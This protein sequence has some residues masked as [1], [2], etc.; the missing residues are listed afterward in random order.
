LYSR[1]DAAEKH[2]MMH[3]KLICHGFQQS[4]AQTAFLNCLEDISAKK[5]SLRLKAPVTG[6]QELQEKL[7]LQQRDKKRAIAKINRVCSLPVLLH[8]SLIGSELANQTL[9][10]HRQAPTLNSPILLTAS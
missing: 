2:C 6:A 7:D 4:A 3:L 1:A 5:V 10:R 9:A 8:C